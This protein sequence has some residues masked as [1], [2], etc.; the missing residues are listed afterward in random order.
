MIFS[1]RCADIAVDGTDV[2]PL[3]DSQVS[4]EIVS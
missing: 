4:K 1:L 2:R 3:V